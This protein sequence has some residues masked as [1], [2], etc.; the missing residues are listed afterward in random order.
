MMS[1]P[2]TTAS[3]PEERGVLKRPSI[4]F[5]VKDYRDDAGLRLCSLAARGLWIE[6]IC[7]M[8]MAEPYGHLVAAGKPVNAQGLARLAGADSPVVAELLQELADQRIYS[9]TADGVIYSRRMVRDEQIRLKR[10]AGGS[11]GKE[12]G[13]LGAEHGAKGGRP[14][15]DTGVQK[16]PFHDEEKP[17]SK[18]APSFAS[19]FASSTS[20]AEHSVRESTASSHA[21]ARAQDDGF[22]GHDRDQVPEHGR[23]F[24]LLD[25][26]DQA[27]VRPLLPPRLRVAKPNLGILVAF[28]TAAVEA[29]ARRD[30]GWYALI[31]MQLDMIA[32]DGHDVNEHLLRTINTGDQTEIL[33]PAARPSQQ[34]SESPSLAAQACVAM[35]EAGVIHCNP[36][37]Q[38]LLDALRDGVTVQQLRDTAK[39]A[40]E[41]GGKGFAWVV[42]TAAARRRDA[43][44][45]PQPRAG[46]GRQ[47][48]V[49]QDFEQVDYTQG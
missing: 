5:Y 37:N 2:G 31:A 12:F 8:H 13:Q 4:Q 9:V 15:K 19:A 14:R 29:G 33:M 32:A 47:N 34:P 21:G 20:T 49:T 26:H 28:I 7:I 46:P 23:A 43:T 41:R 39:E 17:P 3:Q 38:G 16:P 36:S 44:V 24:D 10:A 30:N 6:M 22:D 40:V 27:L 45:Q 25:D 11:A 35:R 48:G 18:P 1:A 42:A